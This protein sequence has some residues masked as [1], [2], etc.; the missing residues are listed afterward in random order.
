MT[1][2]DPQTSSKLLTAAVIAG[3]LFVAVSLLQ[4][5]AREGFDLVRHPASLLS[6]G[7]GGWIQIANF[8][9]T[10]ILYVVGAVGLRRLLKGGIGRAW[11]PRLF[12]VLGIAMIA[13]GVFTVDPALGFPPGAPA[14]PEDPSWHSTIHGFAPPVGFLSLVAALIILGRRFGS[15]GQRTWMWVT[16][17]VGVATFALSS[18][19]SFTG[20]WEAG[21]FN[22][23]PLW[24][25]VALGYGYTSV[26]I[27]KMK[28]E[29][30]QPKSA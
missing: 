24:A 10:G 6:L 13:G 19:P 9:L 8:V 7:D 11:A 12:V 26:V 30:F 27:A 17:L 29:W 18:W 23:L 4:A 16:I 2:H 20:D 1:T 3:P 15:R 14:V 22:F 25:G 21:R 28:R 5:F